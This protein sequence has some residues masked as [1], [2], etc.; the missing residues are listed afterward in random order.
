VYRISQVILCI[1]WF[2]FSI[3]GGNSPFDGWAKF[4]S[5]SQCNLGFSIFLGVVQN[6]IYLVVCGMGVYNLVVMRR[7]Y[8]ED[9]FIREGEQAQPVANTAGEEQQEEKG[10]FGGMF[11]KL[12]RANRDKTDD[13]I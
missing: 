6:L 2:V 1:C 9:P 7:L 4:K 8:G 3:V 12:G 11:N 10:G 5:L 13:E